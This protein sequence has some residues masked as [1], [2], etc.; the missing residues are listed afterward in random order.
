MGREQGARAVRVYG[1][2]DCVVVTAA[3]GSTGHYGDDALMCSAGPV[4]DGMRLAISLYE[5]R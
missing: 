1:E 2:Q 5:Q 4:S 3:S